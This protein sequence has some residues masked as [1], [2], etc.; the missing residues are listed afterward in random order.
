MDNLAVVEIKKQLEAGIRK[1]PELEWTDPVL[2]VTWKNYKLF[3]GNEYLK[4]LEFAV[5]DSYGNLCIDASTDSL[6]NIKTFKTLGVF[7]E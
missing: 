5:K 3:F 6:N 1:L 2:F 4:L 7:W